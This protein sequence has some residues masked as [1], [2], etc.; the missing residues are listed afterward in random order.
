MTSRQVIIRTMLSHHLF[1]LSKQMA[2]EIESNTK[3]FIHVNNI[4]IVICKATAY[5]GLNVLH[6]EICSPLR[7]CVT[8]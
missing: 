8:R 3:L 7:S 5:P 6:N 4:E 1:D 2:I